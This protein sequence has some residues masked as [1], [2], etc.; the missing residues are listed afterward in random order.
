M[1]CQGSHRDKVHTRFGIR[2]QGGISDAARS[3]GLNLMHGLVGTYAAHGLGQGCGV[4]VVEHNAVHAAVV[5]HPLQLVK[6]AHLYLY[7]QVFS[8]GFQI[9][10][11]AVDGRLDAAC[12]VN[13]VV[14]EHHHVVEANAVI[15]TSAAVH[16]IF[17]KQSH[18]GRGLSGVQKTGV[19]S[20]EHLHHAMRLGGYAR[21][22]LHDVEGRAFGR[23]YR[24]R[25]AFDAHD[26]IAFF[27]SLAVV[28]QQGHLQFRVYQIKNT[29]A[30]L[31]TAQY[32]L[33]LG[34]HL[35]AALRR[36][37]YA[38]QGRVVSI[39]N[40]FPQGHSDEFVKVVYLVH[41]RLVI[42]SLLINCCYFWQQ[43]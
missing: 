39:A 25:G 31:G 9:V 30:N 40:V 10:V 5:E 6:V 11:C 42:Y 26:H 17:L 36:C 43:V 21:E 4:E 3:L 23:E 8:F 18:V 34:H 12:K 14:L 29:F 16:R 38:G 13:V 41:N 32:A 7:S 20:V 24:A 1:V 19:Q 15:G 35:G 33:L 37:R 28:H 27:H 2:A 22:A